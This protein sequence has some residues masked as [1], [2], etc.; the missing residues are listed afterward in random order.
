MTV[1][2][3]RRH[4]GDLPLEDYG[5]VGDGTTAALVGRDG[6]VSWLRLPRFDSPAVLCGLLDTDRGGA[7]TVAPDQVAAAGHRHEP[8]TGVLVTE[9][10]GPDGIVELTDA[11]TLRS[12]ADL[13][14]DTP[15]AGASC[16]GRR[17]SSPAGCNCASNLSQ[18]VA[19]PSRPVAAACGSAPPAAPTWTCTC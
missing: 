4:G 5:L 13:A 2:P 8:D 11:L 17:A 1:H 6:S 16:C 15:P 10:H 18:G 12:G 9:L 19:P 7:F 14:E 3:L